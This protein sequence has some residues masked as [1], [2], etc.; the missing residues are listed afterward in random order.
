MSNK[1]EI[2]MGLDISTKCILNNI[3]LLYYTDNKN[4]LNKKEIKTIICKNKLY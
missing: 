3:K 1:N 4:G 2:V